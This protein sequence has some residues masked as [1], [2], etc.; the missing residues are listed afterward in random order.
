MGA[1]LV[2]FGRCRLVI[3]H[4]RLHERGNSR[5]R[6][7]DAFC[8]SMPS[9]LPV[10]HH[11]IGLGRGSACY[12]PKRRKSSRPAAGTSVPA[13]RPNAQRGQHGG[14]LRRQGLTPGAGRGCIQPFIQHCVERNEVVVGHHGQC[15]SR[16]AWG[17]CSPAYTASEPECS[18]RR[19]AGRRGAHVGGKDGG[20][21]AG[22]A[23]G[24]RRAGVSRGETGPAPHDTPSGW[25]M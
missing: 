21:D 23:D 11:L 24:V 10:R 2:R 25:W 20:G 7:G 17:S 22:G 16:G 14:R 15:A 13:R 6:F 3:G 12:T 4:R 18:T 8:I 5:S 19:P 9:F 1:C